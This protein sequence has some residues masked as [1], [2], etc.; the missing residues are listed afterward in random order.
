MQPCRGNFSLG[1]ADIGGG[2]ED[3]PLQVG[4]RDKVIIDKSEAAYTGS[5]EVQGQGKELSCIQ[6]SQSFHTGS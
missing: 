6:L 1:S 3:L 2:K 5:T 4:L